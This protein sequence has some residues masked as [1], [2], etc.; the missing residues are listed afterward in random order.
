MVTF[1]FAMIG[2]VAFA[3]S[4]A[5]TGL[6]KQMDIFGVITL[7]IVTAVGGGVIRDIIIG[8]VPPVIFRDPMYAAVS[9][10]IAAI[11]FIPEMRRVF[12]KNQRL[13]ERFVLI[14]DS[15]GLGIFTV[16][17]IQTCIEH[18]TYGVFLL[19]F[20]GVITGVGGG[21]L[22]DVL[23]GDMPYIFKKHIYACASV[24]GALVCVATWNIFGRNIAMVSGAAVVV[25][26]RIM[27]AHF[28]WNLPRARVEAERI[29]QEETA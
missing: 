23:A 28:K 14:M 10:V 25:A 7:G 22:R 2:T 16:V 6:K 9:A 3:V 5:M 26:V 12:M 4:G 27:S 18:G 11:M 15:V 20:V 17:G 13:Y 21:V 8:M 29:Q 24:I 19:I 1:I